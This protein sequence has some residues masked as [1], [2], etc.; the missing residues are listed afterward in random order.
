M[1]GY[2]SWTYDALDRAITSEHAGGAEKVRIS[3]NDDGST[4]VTNALNKQTT[5]QFEF[6]QGAKRITAINGEPSAG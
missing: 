2:A 6:I 4:K 1:Q 3:Y 5:Y